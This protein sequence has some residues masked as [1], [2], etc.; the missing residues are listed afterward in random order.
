MDLMSRETCEHFHKNILD[1]LDIVEK[2]NA[3]CTFKDK[4]FQIFHEFIMNKIFNKKYIM[5][6]IDSKFLENI[7]NYFS[8]N[9]ETNP[10]KTY[11]HIVYNTIII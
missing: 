1:V 5:K 4:Y 9:C 2:N 11:I 10:I 6:L 3:I 7:L 8:H